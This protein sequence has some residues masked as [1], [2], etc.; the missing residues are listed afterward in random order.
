VC[1]ERHYS[2][3]HQPL[4]APLHGCNLL[5][6]SIVGC[7]LR[8]CPRCACQAQRA[9]RSGR[10]MATPSRLPLKR[11]QPTCRMRNVRP[12]KQV[13]QQRA[14]QLQQQAHLQAA[15]QSQQCLLTSADPC[16]GR[17]WQTQQQ[18]QLQLSLVAQ[19]LPMNLSLTEKLRCWAGAVT[20]RQL[21]QGTGCPVMARGE[22]CLCAPSA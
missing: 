5:M 21:L 6:T 1:Q 3:Q 17:S 19:L 18:L 13:R 15:N 2:T 16:Q 8:N 12:L 9:W 7:R 10:Q 4:I 20:Q 14:Q 22:P 11:P